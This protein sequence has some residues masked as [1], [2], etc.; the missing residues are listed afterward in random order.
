MAPIGIFENPAKSL[1]LGAALLPGFN[2]IEGQK[3]RR[4]R[5]VFLDGHHGRAGRG[6]PIV[7][8]TI[9]PF[10]TGFDANHEGLIGP[11]CRQ[12]KGAISNAHGRIDRRS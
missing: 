9:L 2:R 3:N 12:A 5:L 4:Q 1:A 6:D 7:D 10:S 8:A 11:W